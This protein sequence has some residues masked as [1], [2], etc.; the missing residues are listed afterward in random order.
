MLVFPRL[1]FLPT[2]H[3]IDPGSTISVNYIDP[4][5]NGTTIIGSLFLGFNEDL[6]TDTVNLIKQNPGMPV[7]CR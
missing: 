6:S 7:A 2:T 5:D 1:Q 3:D 4:V